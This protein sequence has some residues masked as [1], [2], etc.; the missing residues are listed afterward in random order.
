MLAVVRKNKATF[1]PLFSRAN[2]PASPRTSPVSPGSSPQPHRP[3][4]TPRVAQSHRRRRQA[5]GPGG[6]G[7]G[8]RLGRWRRRRRSLVRT[9]GQRAWSKRLVHTRGGVPHAVTTRGAAHGHPREALGGVSRSQDSRPSPPI[10]GV[11]G[12]PQARVP[13][14]SPTHSSTSGGPGQAGAALG[15]TPTRELRQQ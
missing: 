7:G 11:R 1:Q 6:P 14:L 10:S 3:L 8:K 5:S 12:K 4:P 13:G 9:M 15:R 2:P